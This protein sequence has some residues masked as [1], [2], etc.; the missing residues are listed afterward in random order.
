M[1][2]HVPYGYLSYNHKSKRL[3]H[4]TPTVEMLRQVRLRHS[5]A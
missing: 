5:I 1:G 3:A 2:V 4:A